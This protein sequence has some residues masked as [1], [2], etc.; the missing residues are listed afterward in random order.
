M[1]VT[2]GTTSQARPAPSSVPA[3]AAGTL[4][5]NCSRHSWP[6]C[7][8]L[9]TPSADS[10]ALSARRPRT[11]AATLM[12]KPITASSAAARPTASFAWSP[13]TTR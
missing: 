5:I 13:A 4:S 3:A 6:A 7:A 9:P 1:S 10:T 2:A 8:D 11:L 12:E